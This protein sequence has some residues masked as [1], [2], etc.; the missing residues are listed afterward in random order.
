MKYV[1]SFGTYRLFVNGI[2]L[3][4]CSSYEELRETLVYAETI[5]REF[6]SE[7]LIKRFL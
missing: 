7:E 3:V 6:G 4:T 5:L 2:H 1:K